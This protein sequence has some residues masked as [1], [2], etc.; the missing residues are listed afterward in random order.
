M[1]KTEIY[2]NFPKE[3][4]LNVVPLKR[5][6]T[7]MFRLVNTF[8]AASKK[9]FLRSELL[10][11]EDFVTDPDSGIGYHIA[12]I[13]SLSAD[14]KKISF[15]E[16][17]F[18]PSNV[19]IIRLSGKSPIENEVY[20]FCK[21][22]NFNKSNPNRDPL[23]P[24]MF[25]EVDQNTD[26]ILP[27]V[28]RKNK[29]AAF[30]IIDHLNDAEIT[31]FLKNSREIPLQTEELRRNQIEDFAERF[32]DLV[33]RAGSYSVDDMAKDV[34]KFIEANLIVWAKEQAGW[35]DVKS[36]QIFYKT[37]KSGYASNAK[38]D[39]VTY[40]MNNDDKYFKYQRSYLDMKMEK[41]E[42]VVTF[43]KPAGELVSDADS[44]II[45]SPKKT[46]KK[47]FAKG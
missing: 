41:G 11:S 40:F 10:P 3:S 7:A 18:D 46:Y 15:H 23:A 44:E 31:A 1:T 32:P 16:I 30:N 38:Q 33:L 27:R 21:I 34:D 24:V 35:V 36:G 4:K 14:G 5:D 6:E 25:E 39:L 45:N 19:C 29:R 17:W 13:K 28:L 26:V 47:A 12:C 20:K 8:D 9:Y 2:N 37:G 22:S 42:S 43:E